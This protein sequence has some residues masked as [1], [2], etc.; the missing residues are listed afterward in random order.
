MSFL[1]LCVLLQTFL[2]VG[3][4]QYINHILER[5]LHKLLTWS[6]GKKEDSDIHHMYSNFLYARHYYFRVP[7]FHPILHCFEINTSLLYQVPKYPRRFLT[8]FCRIDLKMKHTP[9]N[10]YR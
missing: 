8:C 9:E 10:R 3:Y 2:T 1:F 6:W 5:Y 4:I 7:Y